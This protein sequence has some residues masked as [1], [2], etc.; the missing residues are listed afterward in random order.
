[1]AAINTIH[2]LK[3]EQFDSAATCRLIDNFTFVSRFQEPNADRT[4]LWM[5]EIRAALL[6]V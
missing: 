2:R 4:N 1:M 5:R 6:Q 3:I